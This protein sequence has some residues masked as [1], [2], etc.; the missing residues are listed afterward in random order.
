MDARCAYAQV[1]C[2]VDA[3]NKSRWGW[4]NLPSVAL[5]KLH[6]YA[7]W[8]QSGDCLRGGSFRVSSNTV[9]KYSH[10]LG[11]ALVPLT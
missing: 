3:A 9:A 10:K 7:V 8:A 4:L 1:G 11:K 6:L 5:C 2:S